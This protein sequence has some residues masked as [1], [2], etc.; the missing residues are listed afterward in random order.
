MGRMRLSGM[1]AVRLALTER[2]LQLHVRRA[3]VFKFVLDVLAIEED[4]KERRMSRAG[5]AGACSLPI[6]VAKT[7]HF[8]PLFGIRLVCARLDPLEALFL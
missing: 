4:E 2:W 5:P 7:K 6:H 8:Q 1:A 3:A